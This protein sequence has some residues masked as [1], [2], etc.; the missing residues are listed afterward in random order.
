MPYAAAK[1]DPLWLLF[2]YNTSMLTTAIT[3]NVNLFH[4][5]ISV[6]KDHIY[7]WTQILCIQLN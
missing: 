3:I 6:A 2:L 7:Y 4:K 5:L 1:F